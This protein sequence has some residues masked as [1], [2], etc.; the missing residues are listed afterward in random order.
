MPVANYEARRRGAI[1]GDYFFTHGSFSVLAQM[2]Y[3]DVALDFYSSRATAS[4]MILFLRIV[5][6]FCYVHMLRCSLRHKRKLGEG[7]GVLGSS[8][9]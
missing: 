4:L 9:K 8:C 2:G 5:I 3:K 7:S 1:H 6:D